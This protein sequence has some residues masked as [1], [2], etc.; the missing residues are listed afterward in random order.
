V[1]AR[2]ALAI[3]VGEDLPPSFVVHWMKKK[4]QRDVVSDVIWKRIE[5]E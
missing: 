2:E 3:F 5:L 1:D 4:I